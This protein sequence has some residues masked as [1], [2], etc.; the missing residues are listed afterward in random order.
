MVDEVFPPEGRRRCRISATGA[1][2]GRATPQHVITGIARAGLNALIELAGG[3][4]PRGHPVGLLRY[5]PQVQ[6]FLSRC[7]Q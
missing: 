7:C 6:D 4:Q 1:V 5:N 2:L 3:K